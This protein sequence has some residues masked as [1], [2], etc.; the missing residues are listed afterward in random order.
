M[1]LLG[2]RASMLKAEAWPAT[3]PEVARVSTTQF[4]AVMAP[5][6]EPTLTVKGE[7]TTCAPFRVTDTEYWPCLPGGTV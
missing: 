6:V 4:A 5:T 2:S 7:P 3:W 1:A